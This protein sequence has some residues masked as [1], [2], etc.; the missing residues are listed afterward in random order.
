MVFVHLCD[1]TRIL[2][3]LNVAN[4]VA[5]FHD[6]VANHVQLQVVFVPQAIHKLKELKYQ[7]VLAQIITTLE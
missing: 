5:C 2:D 1:D 6:V 4:L 7:I 3:E